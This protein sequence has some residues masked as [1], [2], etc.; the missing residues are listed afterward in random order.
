ML[1]LKQNH[2][3]RDVKV[4]TDQLVD[5]A[6]TILPAS[7]YMAS[8]L[9]SDDASEAQTNLGFSTFGKSLIDD[10]DASTALSTLGVSSF[11]KTLL[12][13]TSA[14]AARTTLDALSKTDYDNRKQYVWNNLITNGDFYWWQINTSQNFDGFGSDDRW[15]NGNIGS[16]KVHSWQTFASGQTDVPGFP[17]DFSRTVVTSVA[18]ASNRV[19]KRQSLE[20]V[21]TLAGKTATLTFWAKAD[22]NRS[23]AIEFVQN[24][25]TGGSPSAAVTGIGSQKFN[26]TTAWQKFQAVVSIPSIAAKTIGT[27]GTDTLDVNFWFEAGSTFNARTVNLGQQSGTFD[28]ARV[29]LLQGDASDVADPFPYRLKGDELAECQRWYQFYSNV[30]ISG[31]NAAN[32]FIYNDIYFTTQMRANPSFSFYSTTYSNASTL[33]SN[34]APSRT[35]HR[36]QAKITAAGAGWCQTGVEYFALLFGY[37]GN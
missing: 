34:L 24:F 6:G 37:N 16:T 31:Y 27:D 5:A 17:A 20:Y 22:T 12:D 1:K 25:G 28:L 32:A 35:H 14:A 36:M 29:S 9:L 8:V 23:I 15:N 30:F 11:A 21:S 19:F 13:D 33:T 10:A 3:P 2:T 4:L 18:G 26:L 7:P